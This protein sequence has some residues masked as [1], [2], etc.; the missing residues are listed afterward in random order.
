MALTIADRQEFLA[1]PLIGALA[2]TEKPG[3]APLNLPIWYQYTPGG[4]LWI[5]TGPESRK[6]RALESAGRFSLMVQVVEPTVRYVTVE[7]PI[8]KVTEMTPEQ[9][10]EM[11]A[12]YLPPAAVEEYLKFAESHGE[13]VAVYMTPENWLSADMGSF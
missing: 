10:R 8:T 4:D 7:G 6:M 13:Q 11:A 2:V 3:R 5:L 1:Q 12:R 9:H